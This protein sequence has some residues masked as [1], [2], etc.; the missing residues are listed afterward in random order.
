MD[1]FTTGLAHDLN[2]ILLPITTITQ[3]V[4]DG[5]QEDTE[6][7]QNLSKVLA[8]AEQGRELGEK[9][10]D[11]GVLKAANFCPVDLKSVVLDTLMSLDAQIPSNVTVKTM[12]QD[13]GNIMGDADQIKKLLL[14][15]VENALQAIG[16]DLGEIEISLVPMAFKNSSDIPGNKLKPGIFAKLTIQDSGHGMT[17]AV[18]EKAF[19]PYFSTKSSGL[20]TGLSLA[21]VYGIVRGHGGDIAVQTIPDQM[22]KFDVYFSTLN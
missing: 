1:K 19:D 10:K 7:W 8:A 15:L 4:L 6:I 17:P 9:I 21:A 2:N 12:F 5:L 16:E 13:V 18:I 22:A 14:M 11:A 20:G 3:V